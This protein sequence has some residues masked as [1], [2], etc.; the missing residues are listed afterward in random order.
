MN[1]KLT[2][3]NSREIRYMRTC[4]EARLKHPMRSCK[5]RLMNFSTLEV[6][7]RKY[8]LADLTMKIRVREKFSPWKRAGKLVTYAMKITMRQ[9]FMGYLRAHTDSALIV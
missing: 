2:R 1:K 3:Q 7:K 4:N 8:S 6:L 9:I 5:I